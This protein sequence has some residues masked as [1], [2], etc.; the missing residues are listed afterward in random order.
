MIIIF[1]SYNFMII[2]LCNK[3]NVPFG[4]IYNIDKTRVLCSFCGVECK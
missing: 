2:K 4:N 3:I 1:N